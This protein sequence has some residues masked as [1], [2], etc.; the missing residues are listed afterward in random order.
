MTY[1]HWTTVDE[2]Y[3]S[4]HY[5]TKLAADIAN[6][7]G[8]ST[9]AIKQRAELLGLTSQLCHQQRV[10]QGTVVTLKTHG[11]SQSA[12]AG[13]VGCSTPYVS[14]ILTRMG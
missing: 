9:A 14:K 13:L 11:L 12:I 6:H 10:P 5:G 3:L 7:L 8:R 1:T 2:R 4:D